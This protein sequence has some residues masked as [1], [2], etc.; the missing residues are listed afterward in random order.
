LFIQSE[1]VDISRENILS[2]QQQERFPQ[3]YTSFHTSVTKNNRYPVPENFFTWMKRSPKLWDKRFIFVADTVTGP[4]IREAATYAMRVAKDQA[5]KYGVDTGHLLNSFWPMIDGS[6][7]S[8]PDQLDG[9][10]EASVFQLVNTAAYASTS[11]VNAVYFAK[12]G[13]ILFYTAK[14][15]QKKYPDLGIAYTYTPAN[16]VTG[17]PLLDKY[18]K[19]HKYDVPTL[20]IGGKNNINWKWSQPGANRK[21]RQ[22]GAR[23]KARLAARVARINESFR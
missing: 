8:N 14:Q 20:T 21:R 16:D 9:L 2:L 13:G 19:Q 10:G 1:K 22:A 11:E 7:M 4:S 12:I 5:R 3:D 6:L 17:V 23:R 15:V 18:G